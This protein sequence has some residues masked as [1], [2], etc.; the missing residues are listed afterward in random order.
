MLPEKRISLKKLEYLNLSY[1]NLRAHF[2]KLFKNSFGLINVNLEFLYLVQ[3][4][5]EDKVV[6]SLI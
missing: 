6:D 3:T 2:N 1:N 4:H 5:I